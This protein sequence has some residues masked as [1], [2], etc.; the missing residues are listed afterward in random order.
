MSKNTANVYIHKDV[1]KCFVDINKLVGIQVR[2]QSYLIT[3]QRWK[4]NSH[5]DMNHV[6]SENQCAGGQMTNIN[7]L[8]HVKYAKHKVFL[9]S[10]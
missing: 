6:Q 8:A 4:F 1:W 3:L 9:N 2:P 7:H 10:Q 5:C